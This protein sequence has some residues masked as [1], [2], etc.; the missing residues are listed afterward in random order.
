VTDAFL[1]NPTS[2]S[3]T[4]S[5]V[6]GESVLIRVFFV[7]KDDTFRPR[8]LFHAPF[9]NVITGRPTLASG[10]AS[11]AQEFT[12]ADTG[13]H[14]VQVQA[15]SIT[16]GTFRIVLIRLSRPCSNATLTCGVPAVSQL[17]D[18]L[19][20]SSYSFNG[21]ANDVL[22]FQ[23]VKT[24]PTQGPNNQAPAETNIAMLVYGPDGQ[25][26][27]GTDGKVAAVQQ[28]GRNRLSVT[29]KSQASGA[30]TAV[31]FDQNNSAAQFSVSASRLNGACGDKQLGC[32]SVVDASIQAPVETDGYT[33][34]AN[35]GDVFSVELARTE[36][37][38]PFVPVGEVYDP[39]GKLLTTV[40]PGSTNNHSLAFGTFAA[41][42]AGKYTI[43]TK[44]GNDGTRAGGYT[45]ALN[46]LN[47]PCSGSPALGCSTVVDAKLEGTLRQNTY[48]LTAA[49]N[50][51]FLVRVLRTGSNQSFKPRV[52]I[53]DPQGN[54]VQTLITSDLARTNFIAPLAG[55]YTVI[56]ADSL[57]GTQSGTY[58]LS[59]A[60]LSRPCAATVTDCGKVL[61]ASIDG[62]L[63]FSTFMY[64]AAAGESFTVRLFNPGGTVQPDIE[65]YDPAGQKVGT[66][67]SSNVRLVD[68]YRPIAGTYTLVATDAS[69]SAGQGSFSVDLLRTK[70]ACGGSVGQGQPASAVVSGTTPFVSYRIPVNA[71]DLLQV[72]SASFTPNFSPL[73]EIY[74]ADGVRLDSGTYSVNR[75]AATGGQYT[76]LL[77][78]SNPQ[79]S[80][81]F[82]FS[83]QALNN[84]AN[85]Q[86]VAC[87]ATA[88]GS[89]GPSNGFRYYQ[90]SLTA[91]DTAK[92]LLTKVSDNFSPQ[93]ELYDPSGARI[94]ATASEAVQKVRDG[95]YLVAVAPTTSSGET[96]S[97]ALSLQR[98][99]N[100]C[101][102]VRL[103]CGQ[104]LLRQ[105]GVAGQIDAVA[106]GGNAGDQTTLRL[107]VRT[108]TFAPF[109]ELYDAAGNLVRSSSTGTLNLALPGNG[110]YTALI[111]DRNGTGTG[112]YRAELQT[113][114]PCAVDD[115]EPPTITLLRPTGG[116]V[117][118]GGSP[119]RV[120]WQSDD[121]VDVTSHEIRLST[122]GGKTFST[123]IAS[124]LAGTAQVYDWAVPAGIA[125]SRSAVM[126][127]TATDAAGNFRAAV[128]DTLA[129]IGSG[130]TENS[131][132]SL[133]YD[134][135]NRVT[136]A[137]YGDG[138]TLQY[139]YDTS[140]NL[141]QI[142]VSGQ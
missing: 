86:Q 75:R 51:A 69:K 58:S 97:F 62:P 121:N 22:N 79:S 72:R 78:G 47:Q 90:L 66:D 45:L 44:D 85:A 31:I 88:S 125:P 5:G 127:V 23:L 29:L 98:P 99:N 131:S 40:S 140:G 32:G 52:D 13:D 91:N 11:L 102:T 65:I 71:V 36:T 37:T 63:R 139:A 16:P 77:S 15:T 20:A 48:S 142:T 42:V 82:A 70:N 101:G 56:V 123:V 122:D 136:Q 61:G 4:V 114:P 117:I 2:V 124:N 7:T 103:A 3:Y 27:Q 9:G 57:D 141:V 10:G 109:V 41:A 6:A 132:V 26:M 55:N 25:L 83:W 111:R 30:V 104:S 87:G 130:F 129:V 95:N 96:G 76:V 24:G 89:I 137:S 115:K 73:M 128:S 133:S 53:Y 34:T 112:T 84:P 110:T 80:G 60:R 92:L 35:A 138:L 64:S 49:A 19:D 14:S 33:V 68:V 28:L 81:A 74:D 18:P 1:T 113:D 119:F 17:S 118:A 120:A 108:G 134:A 46:R 59:S 116:E 93:M 43:L 135:L 39:S 100:P 67:I 107:P 8:L 38:G 21:A 50:D 54:A 106:F 126:R 12:L 94:A 105:I